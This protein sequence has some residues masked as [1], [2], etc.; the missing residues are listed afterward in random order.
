MAWPVARSIFTFLNRQTHRVCR[1]QSAKLFL[2]SSELGLPHPL[3]RRRVCPPP[4]WFWGG[5]HTR[6]RE[7][8]VGSP[9]SY[10]RGNILCGTPYIQ[11][12][13]YFVDRQTR[14]G[15]TGRGFGLKIWNRGYDMIVLQGANYIFRFK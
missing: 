15:R 9:S 6:F 10:T 1:L 12:S 11:Y 3:T 14:T 2:Q 7:R 4:P 5:G 13:M 8:G